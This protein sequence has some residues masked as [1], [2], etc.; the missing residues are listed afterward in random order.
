VH[1][2]PTWP[3]AGWLVLLALSSQVF[4]WMLIGASLPRLPAATA[5]ILLTVQPAGSVALAA[6]L[7]GETPTGWQL[8]GVALVLVGLLTVRAPQDASDREPDGR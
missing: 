4:G 1:L 7:L 2:V 8:G 6:I 3:S 5:S